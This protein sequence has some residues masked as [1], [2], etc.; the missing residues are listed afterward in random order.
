MKNPYAHSLSTSNLLWFLLAAA[1]SA[2]SPLIYHFFG[3]QIWV[4][5]FLVFETKK[6]KR[7]VYLKPQDII[8]L[9]ES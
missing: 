1:T 6:D 9:L 8:T 7:I 5:I 3:F 2:S 4:Q